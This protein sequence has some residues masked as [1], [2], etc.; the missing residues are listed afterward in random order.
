M[1]I[2][3]SSNSKISSAEFIDVL[4]RS[5]LAE[6]RPVQDSARIEQMLT[7]A[8]ILCTAWVE[9]LLIGVARSLSDYA[10]CCYMSDLAVDRAYQGCGIGTE[11]IRMTQTLLHPDAKLVLLAAPKAREYYAHIGMKSHDSAWYVP[12]SPALASR[13]S[14]ETPGKGART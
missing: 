6:R 3:Y 4:N 1:Q 10:Y 5:T 14:K 13:V 9:T 11:L 12:G 8:D 7:A 2:R